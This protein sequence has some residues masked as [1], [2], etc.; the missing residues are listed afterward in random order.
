VCVLLVT[1]G[2]SEYSDSDLDVSMRRSRRSHKRKVN[3]CETS[4]SD[5]SRASTNRDK[6]KSR[7]PP[8]SSDS[9]GQSL[10]GVCAV[11]VLALFSVDQ[12]KCI[13]LAWIR[14][15]HG[16]VVVGVRRA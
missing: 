16:T 12:L 15:L 1:A 11:G 9:E 3:Y 6:M 7:R 2:S 8:T 13:S 4:E 10:G 5:G 14:S